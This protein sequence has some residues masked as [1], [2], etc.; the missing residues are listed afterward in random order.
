MVGRSSEPE[1]CVKSERLYVL[2]MLIL[3]REEKRSM[4]RTTLTA[5]ERSTWLSFFGGVKHN[6]P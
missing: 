6:A 1:A 3:E 2:Y 5:Q 4:R